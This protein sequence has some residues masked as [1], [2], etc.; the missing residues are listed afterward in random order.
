ME[1][2]QVFK[3]RERIRRDFWD[4][5]RLSE[6]GNDGP[7]VDVS[8]RQLGGEV[9]AKLFVKHLRGLAFAYE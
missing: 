7:R 2:L 8:D 9:L 5:G 6:H 1:L 4:E 3:R